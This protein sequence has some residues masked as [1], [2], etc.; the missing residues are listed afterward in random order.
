MLEIDGHSLTQS[1]AILRYI[2]AKYGFYPKDPVE[3]WRVDSTLDA[4]QDLATK[5]LKVKNE[6][7]ADKRV[8]LY[9]KLFET[10]LPTDLAVFEKRI[11]TFGSKTH[12]VGDKWTIAD[13]AWAGFLFSA[14][15]NEANANSAKLLE[16]L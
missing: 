3:G 12:F 1:A 8:E 13:F 11:Q 4:L 14:F 6:P 15:Y 7:D 5:M 16:S 10:D 2:G 9:N